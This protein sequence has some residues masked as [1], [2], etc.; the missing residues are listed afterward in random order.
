ML[1]VEIRP[2]QELLLFDQDTDVQILRMPRQVLEVV[3][4]EPALAPGLEVT[5]A[6][7]IPAARVKQ[8]EII[9]LQQAT[10]PSGT[11]PERR[12]PRL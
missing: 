8:G 10:G 1:I 11:E 9:D 5:V 12:E 3:V 6:Q 4:G 7:I 2:G